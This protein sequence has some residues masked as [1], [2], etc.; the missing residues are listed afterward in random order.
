[1]GWRARGVA[2]LNVLLLLALTSCNGDEIPTGLE[3][4]VASLSIEPDT[5]AVAIGKVA[6]LG[7]VA[8]DAAG[9]ELDDRVVSWA[10]ADP[11]VAV[12][13]SSGQVRGRTVRSIERGAG[14]T[15]GC[16]CAPYRFA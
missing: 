5:V 2:A 4:P 6:Q 12:V 11:S 9:N 13:D 15:A 10:S 16:E 1:V 8:K 3:T 7:V 14:A